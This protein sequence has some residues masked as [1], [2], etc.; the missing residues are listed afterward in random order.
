MFLYLISA[1]LVRNWRKMLI[2]V[3]GEIKFRILPPT[4][5]SFVESVP[6]H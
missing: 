5:F 2:F 1:S 4:F 6:D 3:D